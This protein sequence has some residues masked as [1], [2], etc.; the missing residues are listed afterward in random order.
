MGS[1]RDAENLKAK[2][3]IAKVDPKLIPNFFSR[4]MIFHYTCKVRMSL[5]RDA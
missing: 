1:D 4:I 5:V 2:M 3:L